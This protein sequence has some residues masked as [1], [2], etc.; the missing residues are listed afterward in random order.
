MLYQYAV[1]YFIRQPKDILSFHV[2]MGF[3]SY[4]VLFKRKI[5]IIINSQDFTENRNSFLFPSSL[6][7]HKSIFSAVH[8]SP[9]VGKI[10]E[11]VYCAYHWPLTGSQEAFIT[12]FKAIGGYSLSSD[13]SM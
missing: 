12:I 8:T 4:V 9:D 1:A 3:Q 13:S 10:R 11:N 7:C 2:T 6:L 5:N